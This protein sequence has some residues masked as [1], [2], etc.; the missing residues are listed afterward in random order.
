MPVLG[1]RPHLRIGF[2]IDGSF[3]GETVLSINI[4]KGSFNTE[5]NF[6]LSKNWAESET[7]EKHKHRCVQEIQSSFFDKIV[8]IIQLL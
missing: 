4:V 1:N 6:K 7:V 8:A 3:R 5:S 2:S